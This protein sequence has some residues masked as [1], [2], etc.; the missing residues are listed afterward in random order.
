M[1]KLV[2]DGIPALIRASGSEPITRV[3]DDEAYAHALHQKLLEEAEELRVTQGDER[4]Q[5]LADLHEVLLAISHLYGF[6]FAQILHAAKLKREE[7]G[8]FGSRFF[9]EMLAPVDRSEVACVQFAQKAFIESSGSLLCVRKSSSDPF[10]A[11]LWDVPGGRILGDEDLDTA[12]R[13]EVWEE[14]GL[15]IRPGMPFHAWSWRFP[16]VP[17]PGSR[18]VAIARSCAPLTLETSKNYRVADDHLDELRWVSL[19]EVGSLRLIPT[20]IPAVHAYVSRNIGR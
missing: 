10:E 3:L 7:R 5:E 13:R 17:E 8:G 12:L 4:L 1:G 19:D 6:D 16:G 9:L 14:S 15:S 2:R 11:G 18:V 20:L